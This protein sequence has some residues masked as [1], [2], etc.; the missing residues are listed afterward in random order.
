MGERIISNL[1]GYIAFK[2]VWDH[3]ILPYSLMKADIQGRERFG[4]A[5]CN[6]IQVNKFKLTCLLNRSEVCFV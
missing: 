2:F 4:T 6:A 3:T 5:I 1:A